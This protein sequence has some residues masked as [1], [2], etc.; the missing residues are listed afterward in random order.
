MLKKITTR[1]LLLGA[2]ASGFALATPVQAQ[3][4]TAA[5]SDNGNDIIVTARRSEERLQDVPISITVMSQDAITKRNIS[6][7]TDLAN[8]VPSLSANAN[9]GP[10]KA[11]FAIR[12]FTQEGK[13]S[14]SV[15]VY[16]A[17]VIAP[18]AN[19][20]TTSGNGA[21]P[22][23]LFDLENVQVLKG[24]QGTLFGRNTTGGAILLVPT[25]PKDELGGYVEGS[26]GDYNMHRVQAV[27]NVPINDT[28][29]VRGAMDWQQRDGYLHN[30]SGIGPKDFGN[31]NYIAAR[32]SVV[33]HLTPSLENYMIASYSKSD[34]NGVVPNL[35][36]CNTGTIPGVAPPLAL[37]QLTAPLACAQVARQ[38]AAGANAYTVSNDVPDPYLRIRQWQVINTTTWQASDT[39]TVKNI[40]SYAEYRESTLFSLWGTNFQQPLPGGAFLTIPAIDDGPGPSGNSAAQSTFTEELQVHGQNGRLDWQAGYYMELSNPLGFSSTAASIFSS[41]TDIA[42]FQCTNPLGFGSVSTYSLKDTFNNK[43]FYAQGD[44]KITDKLTFTAGFRYTIDKMTD[45]GSDVSVAIPRAGGTPTFTCQNL[46][47]FN[48]GT[49]NDPKPIVIDN[50]LSPVCNL[51]FHQNSSKPT[52]LLNLQYNFTPNIMGYVKYSRGYR[53]GAINPNNLG[54]PTW[55]PEKVDTYEGGAKTSWRG[56]V[57]GYFNIA[58]FYNDFSDQQLAV[59]PQIAPAYEAV[60]PPQQLIINAGK[61]RI[62]GIEVDGAIKPFKGMQI[63]ASYAY[64]DT[65][66]ESFTTPPLPVYYLSLNT[67]ATLGGPLALAPKN[68]ITVTGTYTL[69]LDE[70]AGRVSLGATFTHT[71]SQRGH[72]DV[73]SPLLGVL[74]ASDLLNV[75]VDWNS[76]MNSRFDLSFFMTNVTDEHNLLFTGGAWQTLGSDGGHPE[77]PQMWGFRVKY[78]FG[79]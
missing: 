78:H 36:V 12:G 22:G 47:F 77:V 11:S 21:G 75:N 44:Y 6:N 51:T 8:Y 53:Q 73:T 58:A 4:N 61:S 2:A 39:I 63:D 28:F 30:I 25:K 20:G 64:L 50:V 23:S 5:Q 17:D 48:N 41:C 18:R 40:I 32:V 70:S 13:T 66:L 33:A 79:H 3:N 54:F 72:S 45:T 76:V 71:D 27:L 52:W 60:V 55:G 31:T 24:P 35:T 10:E 49:I 74:P 34:N 57:P 7:P 67:E 16:F 15:G 59:D 46:L 69:P 68:R 14:P 65:K 43:G 19:G 1:S 9:F 62:W 26:A 56:K 38:Q 29:L 42:A 37:A